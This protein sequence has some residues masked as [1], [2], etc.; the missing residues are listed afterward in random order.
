MDQS[1]ASSKAALA[2]GALAIAVLAYL[3]Q[4]IRQ[5]YRLSHIPGP[6]SAGFSKWWMVKRSLEGR[7]PSAI[8]EVTDRYGWYPI[9]S[10]ADRIRQPYLRR[11]HRLTSRHRIPRAYW[12]Q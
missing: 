7:Q 4:V 3:V 9:R 8:K 5:W 6:F 11:G 1:G 10:G 12:A 2:I